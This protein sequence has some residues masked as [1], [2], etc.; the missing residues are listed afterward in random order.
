MR[1]TGSRRIVVDGA[2]YRWRIRPARRYAPNRWGVVHLSVESADEPGSVLVVFTDRQHSRDVD[3]LPS[4]EV[5]PVLPRH[6]AEWI[7]RARAMGWQPAERGPQFRV[8]AGGGPLELERDWL[9]VLN[10]PLARPAEP[11]GA[12]PSGDS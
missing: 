7:R 9:R 4:E 10:T 1:K 12:L 2:A 3:R 11:G 6:V 8:V 5:Y